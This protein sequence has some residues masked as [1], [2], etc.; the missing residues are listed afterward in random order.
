MKA[1]L[2]YE[3][4]PKLDIELKIEDVAPPTINK[5]DEVVV[6]VGGGRIVPH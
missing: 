6:K 3:Y 5:P 4:D 2:L 1:A